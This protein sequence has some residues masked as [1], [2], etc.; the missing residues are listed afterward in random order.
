VWI[1]EKEF[2]AHFDSLAFL[3]AGEQMSRTS[4]M[5][6]GVLLILMGIQLNL[7]ESFLLT[8]KA[9]QFWTERL[10]NPFVNVS[11]GRIAGPGANLSGNSTEFPFSSRFSDRSSPYSF[12]SFTRLR[13]GDLPVFQTSQSNKSSP[14]MFGSQKS[15]TPPAWLCWPSIFLGAVMFLYGAALGK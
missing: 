10:S 12:P 15:I 4:I 9:T 2:W 1:R 6:V 14:S 5:T 13:Q 3:T 11:D 7:V 8:E